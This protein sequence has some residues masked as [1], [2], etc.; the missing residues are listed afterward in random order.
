MQAR[1][2]FCRRTGPAGADQEV[3]R[4]ATR[5]IRAKPRALAMCVVAAVIGTS[6]TLAA[7]DKGSA[8]GAGKAPPP[9]V[10]VAAVAIENV[11]SERRYIGTIKAIESV[12]LKARVEGFLEKVAFEQGHMVDSGQL[13][14]QIEQAP[15]QADLSSA[16]GKLA[17]AKAQLASAQATLEDKQADFERQAQLVKK[18]DTSQTAFDRAKAARDEAKAAVEEAKA[19]EQQA[20]ATIDSA[21]INLGYTVVRSPIDG[22]IGATNY[23]EGNLVDSSSGTLATVVQLDPIRAVFSIPSA[24]FVRF[25]QKVSGSGTEEA[26]ALFVPRLILP[27]GDTYDQQ[28]KVAFA[29]NQVDAST[30]TIAVYADFPNPNFLLL[31]GQFV[32]ALVSTAQEKREPVVPAAAIQRTRDGAQVYVV[33]DDNRIEQ[34]D[35]KLGVQVGTGYEVTS[36]L[37]GGEIVVVSGVQ[38]VKPGMVVKTVKQ[39]EAAPSGTSIQIDSTSDDSGGS[40]S[41]SGASAS[42]EQGQGASGSGSGSAST[43]SQTSGQDGSDQQG[44][45]GASEAGDGSSASTRDSDASDS[46][47]TSGAS[48]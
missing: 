33:A 18:G 21:E 25:Q 7:D 2:A 8:G 10:V 5:G 39:S 35:I 43:T 32:T 14:Y 20:R 6:A 16:E 42:G 37:Q 46:G 24:D 38:K 22:R 4:A 17:A 9:S 3:A 45:G 26:K 48:D 29:S 44:A 28:G 34:R 1:A 13:L 40:G 47:S 11:S 41:N 30:G 19:S 23:T 15:Y 36:G 12:D 31:P 27:T